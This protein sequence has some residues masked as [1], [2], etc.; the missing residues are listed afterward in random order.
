MKEGQM[1]VEKSL[2]MS[3]PAVLVAGLVL[4]VASFGIA[5]SA[6][7]AVTNPPA[8]LK[9]ADSSEGPGKSTYARC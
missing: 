6:K 1:R 2:V 4:G 9:F 8:T 7:K 3:K 5:Q